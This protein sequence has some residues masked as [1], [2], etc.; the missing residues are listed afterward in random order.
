[1]FRY[2]LLVLMLLFGNV[3]IAE[4]DED[5]GGGHIAPLCPIRPCRRRQGSWNLTQGV[6]ASTAQLPGALIYSPSKRLTRDAGVIR[7]LNRASPDWSLF[8]GTV[9]P[10]VRLW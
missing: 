3:E 9:V 7:G 4:A 10:V 1:V 8:K 2:K 5:T 6:S